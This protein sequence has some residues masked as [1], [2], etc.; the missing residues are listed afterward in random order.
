MKQKETW[1]KKFRESDGF[2]KGQQNCYRYFILR[3]RN[4]NYIGNPFE[5]GFTNYEDFWDGWVYQRDKI[6]SSR[7][8]IK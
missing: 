6:N 2:H 5:P 4:D 1:K 8:R 7:S 3:M